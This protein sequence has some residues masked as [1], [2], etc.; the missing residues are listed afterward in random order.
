MDINQLVPH[1]QLIQYFP[2]RFHG[3]IMIEGSVADRHVDVQEKE[4]A[5]SGEKGLRQRSIKVG[6]EE[7]LG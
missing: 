6:S 7:V 2:L 5:Q 1:A 4:K 3:Q